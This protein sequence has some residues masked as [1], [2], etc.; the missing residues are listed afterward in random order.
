M[1]MQIALIRLDNINVCCWA[2]SI[3]S[4]RFIYVMGC[5]LFQIFA[6]DIDGWMFDR[7]IIAMIRGSHENRCVYRKH[8]EYEKNQFHFFFLLQPVL[9]L[10]EPETR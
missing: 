9:K 6:V 8:S 4:F 3:C 7:G 5:D 2:A 10:R 1:F